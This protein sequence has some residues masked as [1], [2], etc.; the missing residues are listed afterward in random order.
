MSTVGASSSWKVNGVVQVSIRVRG[1]TCT[2][3]KQEQVALRVDRSAT[4][5]KDQAEMR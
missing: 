1:G 3:E 4:G 2:G 5:L